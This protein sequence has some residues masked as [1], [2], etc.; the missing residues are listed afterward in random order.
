MNRKKLKLGVFI[1]PRITEVEPG[2]VHHAGIGRIP[3]ATQRDLMSLLDSLDGVEVHKDLNF[4]QSFIHD[5][6]IYTDGF[7]LNNLAIY[8]WYCEVD[9]NVGSYDLEVLKTLARDIRVVVDPFNFEVGLDKYLAH[10]RLSKAGV[11]VAETV[12]FDHNNIQRVKGVLEKWGRAI[13][14][15]RRGKFGKGVMLIESYPML[16]DM[17]DYISSTTGLNPDK[18]YMLE[19][20]YDNTIDDWVGTTIINGE[21]VYGYRKRTSKWVPLGGGAMKVYDA[22]EV[23][24][25]V[26]QCDVT[27]EQEREALTAYRALGCE[28]VG[29]DFI[30]HKGKPIIVDENTFPGYYED[31]FRQLNKNPA[32]EFFKLITCELNRTGQAIA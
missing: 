32:D 21:L 18:A 7:C 30:T 1:P 6:K 8:V 14:K 13:L 5:G 15:P 11:S 17:V 27:P 4:R 29:F 24:G 12:L 28:I 10:L 2:A 3:R 26:E 16:R 31:I 25:E 22:N 23:G 20:Y 19:R 9:R